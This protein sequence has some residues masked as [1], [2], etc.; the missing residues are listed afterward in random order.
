[1][2]KMNKTM[3][4]RFFFTFLPHSP[5]LVLR[6][7][8]ICIYIFINSALKSIPSPLFSPKGHLQLSRWT[9]KIGACFCQLSSQLFRP[10]PGVHPAPLQILPR[11][12]VALCEQA[13]EKL[14]SQPRALQR[15]DDGAQICASQYAWASAG[16]LRDRAVGRCPL[17]TPRHGAAGD[18]HAVQSLPRGPRWTG[19]QTR[20]CDSLQRPCHLPGAARHLHS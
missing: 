11:R 3:N 13:R 16:W 5:Y 1:M 17:L 14:L 19:T 20:L 7:C 8:I 4:K 2:Q 9:K 12:A 6:P 10:A 18:H 15:A